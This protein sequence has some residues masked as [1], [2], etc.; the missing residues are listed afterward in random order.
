MIKRK[1]SGKLTA[2]YRQTAIKT[3]A[4]RGDDA[5]QSMQVIKLK[6]FIG[7]GAEQVE[8]GFPRMAVEDIG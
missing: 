3:I 1:A 4:K 2:F 7:Q 5:I 8:K 6:S